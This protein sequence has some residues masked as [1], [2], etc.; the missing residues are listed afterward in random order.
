MA[1]YYTLSESDVFELRQMRQWFRSFTGPGVTNAPGNVSI[2][3]QGRNQNNQPNVPVLWTARVGAATQ[4]GSNF[5]WTYELTEIAKSIAG[6][7]GWVD[8]TDGFTA[9]AAYSMAEDQ[10]GASGTM[11]NGV[12]TANLT[13]TYAVQSIPSGT[14]VLVWSVVLDDGTAE[15]WIV[16]MPNGVDGAC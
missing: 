9:T 13:G 14:R 12:D 8:V 15:D 4:D 10:N 3:P 1:K 5:R 11:G 7:D 16:G 6:Y 2:G